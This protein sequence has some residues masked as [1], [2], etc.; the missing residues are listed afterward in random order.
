MSSLDFSPCNGAIM[1]HLCH[2]WLVLFYLCVCIHNIFVYM[3]IVN[4]V[5]VFLTRGATDDCW[6]VKVLWFC[7]SLKQRNRPS[8]LMWM[9]WMISEVSLFPGQITDQ[10]CEKE[11]ERKIIK[12]ISPI[13]IIIHFFPANTNLIFFKKVLQ[14][15]FFFF[16]FKLNTL[17]TP[18]GN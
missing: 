12:K 15:S 11:R 6:D 14:V 4:A 9:M 10:M 13:F 5:S 16:K 18:Q 1:K 7:F 3:N 8:L 2:S 17:F